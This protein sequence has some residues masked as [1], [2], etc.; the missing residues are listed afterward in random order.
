MMRYNLKT[1]M[2]REMAR[3]TIATILVSFISGVSSL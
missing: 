3:F 1:R 2:M